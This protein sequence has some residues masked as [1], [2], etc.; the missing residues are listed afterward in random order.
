MN[1][2]S[3]VRDFLNSKAGWATSFSALALV[4]VAV[5]V[6]CLMLNS[7]TPNASGD[8]VGSLEEPSDAGQENATLIVSRRKLGSMNLKTVRA[9]RAEWPNTVLVTGRIELNAARVAHVSSLVE[10]VVREV[11]VSLGQKVA[12]GEV[13]AYIDSREVGEAKLRL[14]RERLRLKTLLEQHQSHATVHENTMSLLS[15]LDEERSLGEIEETLRDK[16]IGNHWE[17]LVT[18][19]VQLNRAEAEV[20]RLQPLGEKA[21][22]PGKEVLRAETALE[23]AQAAY[24][25]TVEQ[26]RFDSRRQFMA[27]QDAVRDAESA[28]A[29]ARSQLL[30]LGLSPRDIETMDPLGEGERIAYYPVRSPIDGTV[31]ARNAPL[32]KHV[33]A[34]TELVEIADLSTVWL[35]A[36]VFEKD[37]DAV[38]GVLARAVSFQTSG[39]PGR[40]F[41]AEVFSLGDVV[42]D[43]TRATGLLAVAENRENLLKP[44]MFARIELTSRRDAEV[45]QL[46]ASAIQRHGGETFVFVGGSGE[47]FSRRDV[48]IGRLTAETVEI[49]EGLSEGETV[50]VQGG[51]ALKSEML[52][53]LMTE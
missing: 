13:L 26:I 19:L 16:P 21:V 40:D 45:L 24:R 23:I 46:P 25:A 49:L 30:I 28:V 7:Q 36:D 3:I 32:S 35:R 52:S 43:E 27:S 22:I 41:T 38:R 31:I 12:R 33:D 14:V 8:V 9:V 29:V 6:L 11:P 42:H 20:G 34:E 15:L 2:F 1:A 39:Y 53:D 48:R 18:A 50:V 5:G 37:L 51:F 10:G 17:Q 44:G 47:G 4:G